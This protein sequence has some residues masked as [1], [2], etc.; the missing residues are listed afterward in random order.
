MLSAVP[1][2]KALIL[3]PV[4][5]WAGAVAA[6][7]VSFDHDW[8]VPLLGLDLRTWKG[9]VLKETIE[10]TQ[11]IVAGGLLGSWWWRIAGAGRRIATLGLIVWSVLGLSDLLS[12]ES[13]WAGFALWLF[14]GLLSPHL[15]PSLLRQSMRSWLARISQPIP[16][17]A[18]YVLL[19]ITAGV[20]CDAML[21]RD[22]PPG[23]LP[24]LD[25]LFARMLTHSIFVCGGWLLFM[26]HQSLVPRGVRWIGHVIV[27]A[28]PLVMIV[29][30]LLRLWWGKGMIEMFG[31]LEVGGRF[32]LERAWAAGGLELSAG[33]VLGIAAVLAAMF[34]IYALGA[35]LS[36][37][38][39]SS[40]SPLRLIAITS[41]AWLALQVDQM[42]AAALKDRAWSWW[43][44]KTYP[45]RMTWIEPPAG[46]VNYAVTFE[47][48]Q[49]VVAPQALRSKPDVFLFLVESLRWDTLTP[50]IAPFLTRFREEACQ[51]LGETWAASN[52]T[53][54]SWF[55]I[56]S[57]QLP[58]FMNDARE[59]RQMALLPA[60]L[61]ASGYRVEARMV[62]D[63]T[64]MDM[65]A[66]NFGDPLATD[67]MENVG[68]ES[69]ENF[70]KVSE[71]EVRM[72]KRLKASVESRAPGGLF[73]L[74]G[75]DSTHYNYR[76]GNAFTPPF[77]D[78][79]QNPI[80]PMR[81]TP[82]QAR[83]IVHR[84]WNSV[85]W[86]DAQLADFIAFLKAQGRY[87]NAIIIV[88]GDHGEEFKEQG[89]WFHGTQLNEAQ[90]RVPILIKWPASMVTGRGPEVARASHL[91]LVPTL[92]D[93]LGAGPTLWQGLP[94]ISL[95][96]PPPG[97]RSIVMSTHFCGKNGEA[98]VLR[99]GRTLAAF[100]WQDF[101][102][103]GV[104]T[105]MWLERAEGTTR[106]TWCQ[107]FEDI[108]PKLLRVRPL[109]TPE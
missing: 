19:W 107:A 102:V 70:F 51:P 65:I 50:K 39:G 13:F 76:W 4:L 23:T 96:H 6:T 2:S 95:L 43:E 89:S 25:A 44:R 94:G 85:A 63:F 68:P 45:W 8:T 88:T 78:Y 83:R 40:I 73:A 69:S 60:V 15:R 34:G 47:H 7:L 101:W 97:E 75:M 79:E 28:V 86:V 26:L 71:R 16:W 87:D 42:A 1:P 37:R 64:Y 21:L 77:A 80:F 55:S 38:A 18:T 49:P 90:T 66:A 99:R 41:V 100:G 104:P 59:A 92:F 24:A 109:T 12:R 9:H 17:N 91:D 52:V 14:W 46:L 22:A 30:T 20:A 33:T 105:E 27:M 3:W 61:K 84:F 74:T 32:E 103:P 31:E 57:G 36:R 82:K 93:A 67:V 5:A 54:Q 98:L 108:V 106:D 56:L 58:V 29:N 35:G 10:L 53:H 81:P 48:P 72:L 62:N 11:C